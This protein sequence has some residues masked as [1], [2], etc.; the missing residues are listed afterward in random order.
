MRKSKSL[1]VSFLSIVVLSFTV[2]SASAEEKVVGDLEISSNDFYVE[3]DGKINNIINKSS[4]PLLEEIIPNDAYYT[5]IPSNT[6]NFATRQISD[7]FDYVGLDFYYNQPMTYG[8]LYRDNKEAELFILPLYNG[9]TGYEEKILQ[10]DEM[11]L[12]SL[13]FSD[14]IIKKSGSDGAPF[15]F[16][17]LMAGVRY[18]PSSTIAQDTKVQLGEYWELVNDK[19]LSS[20]NGSRI[21]ESYSISS[22]FSLTEAYELSHTLG[23]TQYET[24]WMTILLT[25]NESLGEKFS[26]SQTITET[27]TVTTTFNFGNVDPNGIP[28]IG[29]IYQLLSE[30]TVIPGTNMQE[31]INN[32]TPYWDARPSTV[33]IYSN[34]HYRQLQADF[35]E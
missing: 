7:P 5:G 3:D 33:V 1:L 9:T 24:N 2:N 29:G 32:L 19:S 35:Y 16:G 11:A 15:E 22:G 18:H 8:E 26:N 23:L 20:S 25:L 14:V 6:K 4:L 28:Y 34:N 17:E 12:Y 31:H 27:E 21:S 30:F 13:L 10:N